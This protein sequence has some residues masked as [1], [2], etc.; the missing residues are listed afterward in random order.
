MHVIS[1]DSTSVVSMFSSAARDSNLTLKSL[2]ELQMLIMLQKLPSVRLDQ[3]DKN[4]CS[5][6]FQQ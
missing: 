4:L 2:H 6:Q 1:K 5:Y 3:L